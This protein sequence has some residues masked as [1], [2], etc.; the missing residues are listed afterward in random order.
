M[1]VQP[2][3]NAV[4]PPSQPGSADDLSRL[5]TAL[6]S[7]KRRRLG[8]VPK[9]S[10]E[11][12]TA[13][14]AVAALVAAGRT[15]AADHAN[16][17]RRGTNSSIARAK[18][19]RAAMRRAV[20]WANDVAPALSVAEF[21]TAAGVTARTRGMRA[22]LAD[23]RLA[24]LRGAHVKTN[25]DA[26]DADGDGLAGDSAQGAQMAEANDRLD[27]D[28]KKE[29]HETSDSG[30]PSRGPGV[31]HG[32]AVVEEEGDGAI[33]ADVPDLADVEDGSGGGRCDD[34]WDDAEEDMFEE[35]M[36]AATAEAAHTSDASP[37]HGAA[38]AE[39]SKEPQP[40]ASGAVQDK[41]IRS[42]AI[43]NATR[44]IGGG[45]ALEGN[46]SERE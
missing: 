35:M 6:P 37:L 8:G 41:E 36:K 45:D 32:N 17:K 15:T 1:S 44:G 31:E 34:G 7:T 11:Q 40:M 5:A 10:V 43:D 14:A 4:P 18:V 23:L 9:L 19:L 29:M 42:N 24:Q 26:D 38:S 21:V 2:L 16:F 3:N 12:L 28:P 30:G 25:D 39:N 27:G 22:R 46:Q 13:P 33:A 20:R